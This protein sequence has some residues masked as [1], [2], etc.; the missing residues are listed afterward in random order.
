M[1]KDSTRPNIVIVVMDCCRASDF[2]P[3]ARQGYL[4]FAAEL[5]KESIR[6]P[7][8]VSPSSWTLPSHASLF[9][10]LYPWEH[11]AHNWGSLRL[12][13]TKPTLAGILGKSGYASL[14]ASSN[15]LINTKFGLTRGFD[16]AAWGTWWEIYLHLPRGWWDSR[17]FLTSGQAPRRALPRST[18]GSW[19]RHLAAT[20]LAKRQMI[21]LL[22]IAQR[23]L[24]GLDDDG[25]SKNTSPWIE[26]L[27][28][29]WL[30]EVPA[31]QPAF[32]FV[33][34]LDAHEPYFSAG[35]LHPGL[36][37]WM[38]YASIRQDKHGWVEEEWSATAQELDILHRLYRRSIQNIDS[39][40][41]R[42]VKILQE[43]NRW[44]NTL[45]ILTADHGQ[46]F[47]EHGS[48]FHI[49]GVFD[50]MVRIPLWM[51]MPGGTGGGEVSTSWASLIDVMPTALETAGL[52]YEPAG[53][54]R[55]LWKLR[56]QPRTEPIYTISDGHSFIKGLSPEVQR[57]TSLPAAAFAGSWKVIEDPSAPGSTRAFDLDHDPG[58]TRN[59]WDKGDPKL[60]ELARAA[61]VASQSI[62]RGSP[63]APD[64]EVLERLQAWGYA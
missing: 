44:D 50:E 61:A 52:P 60:Q 42:L 5:A 59:L 4:P 48:L 51:R 20:P 1:T 58:E 55:S 11:E 38:K 23:V 56:N 54:G 27:V 17:R 28:D 15:F 7:R 49:S 30:E 41:R 25:S 47:G 32:C 10:G 16:T 36:R 35:G 34:Y 13:E 6:F 62:R 21:P 19:L 64:P 12:S 57:P 22:D 3:D 14:S 26:P 39:R 29:S 9:T 33:N 31:Q 18:P 46:A 2:V 43:H 37:E 40:L 45:L 8:A 24:L 53:E 63:V